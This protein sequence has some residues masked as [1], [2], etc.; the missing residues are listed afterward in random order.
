MMLHTYTAHQPLVGGAGYA[1]SVED[2]IKIDDSTV[3][4]EEVQVEEQLTHQV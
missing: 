1:V 2:W 4:A 3:R